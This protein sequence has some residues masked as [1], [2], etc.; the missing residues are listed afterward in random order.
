MMSPLYKTKG[1]LLRRP[2]LQIH[3]EKK[4]RKI[5]LS[6]RQLLPGWSSSRGTDEL[7]VVAPFSKDQLVCAAA[8]CACSKLVRSFSCASD[9]G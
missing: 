8:V 6:L 2:G 5:A 7:R 1:Q 4:K 9:N 3:R